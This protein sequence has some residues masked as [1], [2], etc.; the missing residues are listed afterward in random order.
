MKHL[1][2]LHDLDRDIERLWIEPGS[3]RNEPAQDTFIPPTADQ[4]GEQLRVSIDEL[5]AS[6]EEANRRI[7]R[8]MGE[9]KQLAVL[10]DKRDEQLQRVNRELGGHTPVRQTAVEKDGKARTYL[11]YGIIFVSRLTDRVSGY[12]SHWRRANGE[13][14]AVS[15]LDKVS[16][17]SSNALIVCRGDD[18]RQ[19]IIVVLLLGMDK[20]EIQRLSQI[21]EHDCASKGMMPLFVVDT[22]AFELLRQHRLIFEYLPPAGDRERFDSSLNWNLYIQRRLALIRRKWDPVRIVAFGDFA[23]KTLALWASSPFEETALPAVVGEDWASRADDNK[24]A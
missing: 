9:K 13:A 2:D 6:L 5:K 23:T 17:H 18:V 22:D 3:D 21:V 16:G 15:Q 8:L 10:L 14:T 11:D 24:N 4:S 12:I 7:H 20:L 19:M 1:K